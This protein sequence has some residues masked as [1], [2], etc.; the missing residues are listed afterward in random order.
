[1]DSLRTRTAALLRCA[2]FMIACI[3]VPSLADAQDFAQALQLRTI[4]T[5]GFTRLELAAT[6]SDV[7]TAKS[8]RAFLIADYSA[9]EPS[10]PRTV[11]N[12]FRYDPIDG[13]V[14]R[15]T[16]SDG[17][18]TRA[19]FK[20]GEMSIDCLGPLE[21]IGERGGHI[22]IQTHLT[23]SAGCILVLTSQFRPVAALSG[24]LL[25]FAGDGYAV[26]RES[27]IHLDFLHPQA[28]LS[29]YDGARERV[30]PIYP[31][32]WDVHGRAYDFGPPIFANGG[33]P[34][35]A[36]AATYWRG[37]SPKVDYVFTLSAG[38]WTSRSF[39]DSRLEQTFGVRSLAE[40]MRAA[41]PGAG[42]YGLR[43]RR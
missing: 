20:R 11:L 12:V 8:G 10:A 17:P 5:D 15:A 19:S 30:T 27:E 16:L 23:P 25:G 37:S 28:A 34:A 7:V 1:M 36:I 21:T 9:A 33:K 41:P 39:P 32:P 14:A 35:F 3:L 40:L 38:R 42:S 18:D 22:Y 6:V 24:W 31:I 43:V 26:V 29:V 4:P 13:A 2:P